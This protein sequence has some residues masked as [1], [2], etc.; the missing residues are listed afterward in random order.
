[1]LYVCLGA[2]VGVLMFECMHSCAYVHEYDIV[3]SI[4]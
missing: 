3:I 4:L 1:M 2:L